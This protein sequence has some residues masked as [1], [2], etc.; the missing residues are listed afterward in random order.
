M[1]KICFLILL[2][3]SCIQSI[4]AQFDK[5]TIHQAYNN[6]A[7]VA[8]TPNYVFAVADSSLYAYGKEDQSLTTYSKKNGLSDNKIKVIRYHANKHTL[9]IGYRNGNIDLWNE[10]G[11]YNLP[12]LKNS[13]S[14]QDKTIN[15]IYFSDN[16]A[17]ISA[18]VGIVV[19]NLTKQEITDTYRIGA[20]R[21]ACIIGNT[22]YALT[23]TGIRQGKLNDNLLDESNWSDLTIQTDQ[24]ELSNITKIADFQNKLC[25]CVSAKGVYYLNNNNVTRFLL[26]YNLSGMKVENGKLMAFTPYG[27]YVSTDLVNFQTITGGLNSLKDVTYLQTADTYWLACGTNGIMG[28]KKKSGSNSYDVLVDGLTINSPKRNYAW[29]LKYEGGKL[30]VTGGGRWL[31]RYFRTN[32]IMTYANGQWTNYD[33]QK[34]AKQL[35]AYYI[36]DALN[37]AVDPNDPTHTYVAYYG[38]GILELKNDTVLNWFNL[39][40]SSLETSTGTNN[41][42]IRIGSTTLD[43][44]G[45]LWIT[46]CNST[47]SIKIYTADGQWINY[48][49]STIAKAPIIDKILITKQGYKFVNFIHSTKSGFFALN[50]NGTVTDQSDDVSEYYAAVSDNQGNTLDASMFYCMTEDKDGYIWAG[51]NIGPIVC[52]NPSKIED[53]RFNRIVLSDESDYLLNGVRVNAI[54]VDGSNQK[55]IATDGS[56]VFLVNADGTEVIENFTTDNSPLPTNSINSI[57]INPESGEVFFAA[58]GYGVLS[59]QGEAT[60]GKENYSDI[61]A[62]PNPV[63][64]DFDDK[65]IITGLMSNSNV[66]ITDIAGNLIYQT[67]SVGGQVSWNCK[68][69]KG[70]RVA[71]GVYL[72]LAATP[73][74]KESVVTKIMVI[75]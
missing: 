46:N 34:I 70:N 54:A 57:A 35:N 29:D 69:S 17:Y 56:G 27:F 37:L 63:R 25:M 45:N 6:T 31:D 43:K 7:L 52:Y 75:K 10:S 18:Q 22:L 19:V 5:W 60:E 33:E 4:Y 13:T 41:R 68:N 71:T 8:E 67:K 72:V 59:Y 66:K 21:S 1:N 20:V 55:W 53:L 24:F 28:V 64:P 74:S 32:T 2:C 40:N 51:T 58:D 50:D 15:D 14:I 62:Y 26:D 47:Y 30:W 39:T 65:V 49:N 16:Y 23:S 3:C 42:Y 73:E 38:E 9:V 36:Q 48:S 61:H 12:Y 11:I 44:E